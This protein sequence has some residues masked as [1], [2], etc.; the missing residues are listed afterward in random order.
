M[1]YQDDTTVQPDAC[2]P[3]WIHLN[4]LLSYCAKSIT[5]PGNNNAE[6]QNESLCCNR[7]NCVFRLNRR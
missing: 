7:Q 1:R 2:E 5:Q 3:V 4:H 6:Q